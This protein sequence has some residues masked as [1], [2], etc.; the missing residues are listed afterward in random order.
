MKILFRITNEKNSWLSHLAGLCALL[1]LFSS[2]ALSAT[3]AYA[4]LHGQGQGTVSGAV[5]PGQVGYDLVV[6]TDLLG[7]GHFDQ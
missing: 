2:F 4:G 7:R 5:Q 3:G 1:L 6:H